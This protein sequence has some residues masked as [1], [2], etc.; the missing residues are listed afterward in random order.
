[1]P[2]EGNGRY[3][4]SC[5][6]VVVDFSKYTLEEI[7]EYFKNN[8][9]KE[10]CGNFNSYH[11]SENTFKTKIAVSVEQFFSFIRLK[12]FGI[13]LLSWTILLNSCFMGKRHRTQGYPMLSK[14]ATKESKM[15]KKY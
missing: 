4:G 5:S 2:T 12:K 7:N 13:A 14:K 15:R 3:C 1:M 11:T 9:T 6:K 8:Y 10:I